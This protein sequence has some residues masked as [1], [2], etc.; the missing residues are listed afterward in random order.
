MKIL[1]IIAG[2]LLIISGVYCFMHPVL[3]FASLGWLV[4]L[5]VIISGAGSL[6]A[7]WESRKSG[8]SNGWE[9]VSALLTV[10]VGVIVLCNLF[11]MF[12]TDMA[13]VALFGVWLLVT[14]ILRIV[15]S[16]RLKFRHWGFGAVWGCSTD[17]RRCLCAASP[18]GFDDVSGLVRG[19]RAGDTGHQPDLCRRC[20][21]RQK[22]RLTVCPFTDCSALMQRR[23]FF[24]RQ[25]R[26][27]IVPMLVA[28]SWLS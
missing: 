23:Y 3:T 25:S 20:D 5:A 17:T 26:R 1:G 22:G 18:Y 27:L 10:L 24:M 21:E 11:A 15:A 8:S 7:W 19:C 16:V 28:C 13:I 9:L 6:A 4:G 14:G 2:L 12:L